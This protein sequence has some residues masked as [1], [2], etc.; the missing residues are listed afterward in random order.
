MLL[1]DENPALQPA[2]S[3]PHFLVRLA[4]HIEEVF[5]ELGAVV[6][7]PIEKLRDRIVWVKYVKFAA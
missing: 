3:A 5:R 1:Q 6:Y 7:R 2:S 4:A